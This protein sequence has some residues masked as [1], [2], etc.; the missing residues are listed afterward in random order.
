MRIKRSSLVKSVLAGVLFVRSLMKWSDVEMGR[1]V[2]V[3]SRDSSRECVVFCHFIS[4]KPN[5]SRTCS[6]TFRGVALLIMF[7][8]VEEIKIVWIY[9]IW[10]NWK[11]L[12]FCLVCVLGS[13]E[14]YDSIFNFKIHN[15]HIVIVLAY[16][17]TEN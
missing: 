1:M 6:L 9:I 16:V 3:M 10:L 5:H 7:L 4:N 11:I 2:A 13:V 14:F 12:S 15:Q 17:H 8:V